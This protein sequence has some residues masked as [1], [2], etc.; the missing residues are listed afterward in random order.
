MLTSGRGS[1]ALALVISTGSRAASEFLKK[2]QQ[3]A[4]SVH[5]LEPSISYTSTADTI[6]FS[7]GQR[8][9]SLPSGNPPALRGYTADIII[10]DEAAYIERP[11]DVWA[12]IAPTLTRNP[13]AQL[14]IASTP[15]G[16]ASWFYDKVQE[17]RCESKSWHF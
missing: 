13:D 10:I 1:S 3:V 7:T 17:A 5:I 4:E 14:A 8:I 2:C 6:K 15:A 16:K 12:A 9:V 11:E